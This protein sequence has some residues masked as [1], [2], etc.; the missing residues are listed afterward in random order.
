MSKT[1]FLF[2]F[3]WKLQKK[4]KKK[5]KANLIFKFPLT[6]QFI[7]YEIKAKLKIPPNNFVEKSSSLSDSIY[8]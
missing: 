8:I 3:D 5:K 7:L 6:P 4:T 1:T 2:D